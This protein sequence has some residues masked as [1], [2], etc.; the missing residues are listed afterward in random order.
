MNILSEEF[1]RLS[2][3]KIRAADLQSSPNKPIYSNPLIKS[4]FEVCVFARV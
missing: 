4:G 3:I 2:S 1:T